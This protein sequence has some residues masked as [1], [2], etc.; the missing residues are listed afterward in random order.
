MKI[1]AF[2]NDS[3]AAAGFYEKGHVCLYDQVSGTW[4]IAKKITMEINVEMSLAEI[5]EI[6]YSA[7]SQLE[8]CKV[9]IVREFKGLFHALLMEELGFHTWKSA[10]TML[11]QLDNVVGQETEY[12]AELEK[13]AQANA[14]KQL[15]RTA[16]NGSCGG[17]CS[18]SRQ[19]ATITR[20]SE[21][22]EA[23]CD[24]PR[25]VLISDIKEGCY[26]INLAEILQDNPALNS[27]QVLIPALEET[28]FKKLEI[29]CDHTPRWFQ[30][31]LN[32]L[33]L[34][35]EPETLDA[36]GHWLKIVVVPKRI[37]G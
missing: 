33:N 37:Q 31:E 12:V 20:G 23:G 21:S 32:N 9:F 15:G 18:S 34:M 35:A 25:P 4:E 27:R 36:S 19:A 16:G 11:E 26:S 24:V 8:D 10:G 13:Q 17:D 22:C 6:F 29:I 28:S 3:G 30:N 7:M 2:V 1:A 14:G 5:K